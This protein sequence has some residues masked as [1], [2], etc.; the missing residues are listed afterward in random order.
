MSTLA[1]E[2][3]DLWAQAIADLDTALAQ[4]AQYRQA[5]ADVERELD[6]LQAQALLTTQGSNAETRRALLT[7]ALSES[8]P[9]N[10]ALAEQ[11]TLSERL[12]EAERA[13]TVAKERCRLYQATAQILGG[14]Q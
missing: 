2:A 10:D 7:V 5:L 12:R 1:A 6:L 13:V 9:Y 11:R 4:A 8:I 3:L 14:G